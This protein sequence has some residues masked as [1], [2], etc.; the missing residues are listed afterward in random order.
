MSQPTETNK[1]LKAV[2]ALQALTLVAV[3]AA[4]PNASTAQAGF[5]DRD[6]AQPVLPNSAAQRNEMIRLL[7]LQVESNKTASKELGSRFDKL[8]KQLGD[9]ASTL[10]AIEAKLPDPVE[11]R[12]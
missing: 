1:T 11:D 2:I 10:G 6:R 7:A 12:P 8:D 9:I 5:G 4:Q 3:L